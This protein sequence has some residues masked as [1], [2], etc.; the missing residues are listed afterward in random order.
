MSEK[1]EWQIRY[2]NAKIPSRKIKTKYFLFNFEKQ[3][4]K[5][6]HIIKNSRKSKIEVEK[7][8]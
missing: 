4:K 8:S 5:V 1:N 2:I 7:N 6:F 3:K